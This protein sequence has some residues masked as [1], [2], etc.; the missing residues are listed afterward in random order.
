MRLGLTL[1]GT[2]A[3]ASATHAYA[4][5]WNKHWSVGPKPELRIYTNDASVVVQAGDGNGIDATLTTRGLPIGSNG[6]Q[7]TEHQSGN[8]VDINVK[9]PSMHF[10]FGERSIK[11]EVRVPRELASEVHT[12]DG[13]VHLMGLHGSV[14][15]D[16]GDGSIQAEDLDGNFDAHTGDGSVH[17]GGR[18]DHVLLHTSDGSVALSAARGS[19]MASDW[20]V[21]TGDGSVRLTVPHELAAD[22][23]LAT[24]D[25]SIHSDLQLNSEGKRSGGHWMTGKLNGGGP[26]L[27]VRTGDGSISIATI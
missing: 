4:D 17:V 25:G 14:R 20:K 12:G 23:E 3:L 27:R 1:I 16:T 7:V 9:A 2:L 15:A 18:F 6:V 19:R 13:S 24:G 21:E 22:V 5:Q 11:L 10:S 8:S 26:S